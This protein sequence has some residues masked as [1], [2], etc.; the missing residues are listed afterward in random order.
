MI[1][2]PPLPPLT[3]NEKKMNISKYYMQVEIPDPVVFQLMDYG[4]AD[5]AD[6][7]SPENY[8][9]AII[10]EGYH[11]IVSGWCMLPD[12]TGTYTEYQRHHPGG[13]VTPEMMQWWHMWVNVLPK[14]SKPGEGNLKYKLWMPH[15][16]YEHSFVNGH[17]RSDGTYSLE[18]LDAGGLVPGLASKAIGSVRHNLKPQDLGFSDEY[19]AELAAKGCSISAAYETF[20][21][22]G[23]HFVFGFTRPHPLGGTE[24]FSRE[25]IGWRP[26]LDGSGKLV[27][28]DYPCD[29]DYLK[30]ILIH[31]ALEHAHLPRFLPELYAEYKDKPMDAD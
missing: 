22:P 11:K 13:R 3:E 29:A 12:G 6:M 7:L 23:A 10:L 5:P 1:K 26:L 14:S 30:A 28:D 19:V 2:V 27:R 25:W 18:K 20:D 8:K 15:D 17:D 24:S 9:D 16:H 21:I 4:P 31:N